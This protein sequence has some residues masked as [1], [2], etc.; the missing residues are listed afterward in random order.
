MLPVL[1]YFEKKYT[2]SQLIV[3]AHAGL[4]SNTNIE[5]LMEKKYEYILGARIKNET[6]AIKEQILKLT[7]AD[8]ESYLVKKQNQHR[9][10]ISYS[11]SRA[12]KDAQNR[13]RGIT[14]LEKA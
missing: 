2:H 10:I 14:K 5:Q 4:L 7:P 9:L 1:E 13:K 11:I 3:V 8:G 6:E 12:K